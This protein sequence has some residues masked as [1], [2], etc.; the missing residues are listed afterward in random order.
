MN[1][2][3]FAYTGWALNRIG[4][5]VLLSAKGDY[6]VDARGQVVRLPEDTAYDCSGLCTSGIK[7]MGGPDLRDTWNAQK[8][9]DE[10]PVI[11]TPEPG[12][13]GCYGVDGGHVIHVVIALA[14][15]HV[16][17]ADGATSS[18]RTLAD[19]RRAG[20]MVRT[21]YSHLYRKDVGFLGWRLN[22]HCE[23]KEQ[24]NE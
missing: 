2:K 14:G 20:A 16:L 23:S 13:F 15:G 10:L 12:D 21:H 17:S 24:P 11:E 22:T 6:F 7:A 9:H 8:F 1:A 5:P 19:A 18:I 3:R 4:R